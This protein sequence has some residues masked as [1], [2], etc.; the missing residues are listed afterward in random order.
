MLSGGIWGKSVRSFFSSEKSILGQR[1][2]PGR[3]VR[4]LWILKRGRQMPQ[5]LRQGGRGSKWEWVEETKP[6]SQ[7]VARGLGH[8]EGLHF[9]L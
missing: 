6:N 9:I 1:G 4:T 5:E 3:L 8:R 7:I 2:D